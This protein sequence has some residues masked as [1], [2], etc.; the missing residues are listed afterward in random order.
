MKIGLIDVDSKIPNLALMKIS[1]FHKGEGDIV[2][3]CNPML[4]DYD[5]VYVAK[6]FSFTPDISYLPINC[7]VIRGGSG[8]DIDSKLSDIN[9]KIDNLCPDYSLYGIDYAM[10][11]TSRGCIR[12]CGFCIV[13]R[14]EGRFQPVADIH[15][16]WRG[17]KYAMLLDN[18][19]TADHEHFLRICGQ[20]VKHKICTSFRQ[21]LDIR[22]MDE[23]KSKMLSMVS[24]WDKKRIFFAWDS[25]E[26]E[27]EVKRGIETVIRF[28]KPWKLTFYVLIGWDTTRDEDMYRVEVLKSYGIDSFVMPYDKHDLYQSAFARWVNHKAVFNSVS[29]PDYRHGRW[30]GTECG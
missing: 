23:E 7:E 20:L 24:R 15:Q 2:E 8:Y 10:G 17:E 16:F 9:G 21:G 30:K 22:L 19:L 12:N 26:V 28:I 25:M 18:N 14:K 29:W 4:N 13:P 27:H 11:F 3:F 1:A 5:R 6:V